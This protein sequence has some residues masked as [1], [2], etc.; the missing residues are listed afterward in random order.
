MTEPSRASA[1]LVYS[2]ELSRHVLSPNHPMR[3][4]QLRYM[5]ELMRAS[6]VL[7]SPSL[8]QVE[9]RPASRE[10][11]LRYHDA[12]YVDAVR[13]IGAGGIVP[14]MYEFGIG[15]GDNPPRKGIYDSTALTAG[16]TLVAT[17]LVQS[18]AVPVA[19]AP[20][21]GVH[22][23]AMSNRASGFGVFNDAAIAIRGLAD[24]GLR[25]A[26]VDI[27]C[28]HGDGVQAAFY[29]TDRVLTISL[30]EGGQW[31][32]PG[33][34]F[35]E[36]TGEG[37]GEGYSV[38]VPLAPYT[39]DE[40]WLR[41]FDQLVPPLVRS[42][43][44]DVL[45]VQLGIDTHF[46]DP[47][48]HLQL[49]TQGFTAAVTRLLALGA[50]CGRTVAVGG[51]GYDMGAVAR[52]WTMA[53]AEMTGFALPEQVPPDYDLVQ[54]LTTFADVPGPPPLPDDT[55]GEVEQYADQTVAAVKKA[56]FGRFGL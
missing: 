49:T 16:G 37:A 4:V 22:H 27:D 13:V 23:H 32:F 6:G 18:G 53:M 44:P 3:P 8:L 5:H 54:G 34:G 38:N 28:H 25:V 21:G 40:L 24:S 39:Q 35:V 20:A 26:Y 19:F 48:T 45:F 7:D 33:S 15:P 55:A 1:A 56:V 9:P 2:D 11:I 50:E 41:T 52:A 29:G 46:K 47:L 30:H 42:F 43:K 31:L 10:E 36:E 14:N 12:D 17:E 51:G